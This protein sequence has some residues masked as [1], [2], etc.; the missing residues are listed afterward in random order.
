MISLSTKYMGIPIESPL[1]IGASNLSLSPNLI[2]DAVPY[3]IG[4]VIY[5]TL[6][7]EV[8]QLKDSTEVQQRKFEKK[9]HEKRNM[10]PFVRHGDLYAHL[11]NV[12]DLVRRLDIPVI[13]SL[14]CVHMDSWEYYAKALEEQGVKGLELNFSMPNLS[15]SYSSRHK[16]QEQY[17]I[18][19]RVKNVV[20]IPVSVKL[21]PFYTNLLH[22]VKC[23]DRSG[24]DGMVFFGNPMLP[25]IDTQNEQLLCDLEVTTE[26]I[27]HRVFPFI[28]KIYPNT[29]A[30]L[31]G[32]GGVRNGYDVLKMILSGA[33][34]VQMVSTIYRHKLEY[35]AQMIGEIKEWMFQKDYDKLEDFKGA[36]SFENRQNRPLY[37]RK[38]Y[39]DIMVHS[40]TVSKKYPISTSHTEG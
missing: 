39:V 32:A 40:T 9:Q 24:V 38:G 6:F 34:A 37:S 30:G 4:A 13:G 10:F 28:G 7:E 17:R 27:S 11:A 15:W 20:S 18:V 21:S 36:L 22:H 31:I 1:V 35:I 19:E 5:P 8:A 25:D 14:N 3:G 26:A 16:E 29:V 33:D 2:M 12:R 23:L